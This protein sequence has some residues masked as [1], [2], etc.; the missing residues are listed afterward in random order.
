MK[1]KYIQA[2]NQH[3][4]DRKFFEFMNAERQVQ[5]V[6]RSLQKTSETMKTKEKKVERWLKR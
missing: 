1:E 2:E 6:Y 5:H 3:L 4:T